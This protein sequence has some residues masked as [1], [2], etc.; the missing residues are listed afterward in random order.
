MPMQKKYQVRFQRVLDY[1]NEHLDCQLSADILSGVAAFSKFHFHRQFS[2][3]FGISVYK[4]GMR[5]VW[6]LYLI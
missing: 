1:I 4:Y 6:P 3:L 5:P 2:A